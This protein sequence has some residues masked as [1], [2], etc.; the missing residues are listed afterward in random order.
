MRSFIFRVL[1]CAVAAF[2]SFAA[3][4]REKMNSFEQ[5]GRKVDNV[6][7]RMIDKV[8]YSAACSKLH[9]DTIRQLLADKAAS[10]E[11]NV[12][13]KAS[14]TAESVSKKASELSDEAKSKAESVKENAVKVYNETSGKASAPVKPVGAPKQ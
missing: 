3:D 2:S 12:R 5:T 14:S 11:K 10:T 8:S 6:I 7:T 13:E 4:A 9:F 1:F